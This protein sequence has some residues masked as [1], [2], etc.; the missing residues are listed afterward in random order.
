MRGRAHRI[1]PWP[2]GQCRERFGGFIPKMAWFMMDSPILDGGLAE[3]FF[4]TSLLELAMNPAQKTRPKRSKCEC[5]ERGHSNNLSFL[6]LFMGSSS[7]SGSLP[8]QWPLKFIH[9]S[10]VI[11]SILKYTYNIFVDVTG[12]YIYLFWI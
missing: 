12:C 8:L 6:R 9:L 3:F 2:S 11:Q 10:L 7:S 4:R 5:Y 1:P